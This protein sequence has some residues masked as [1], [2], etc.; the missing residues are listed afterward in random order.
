[1]ADHLHG[2]G[3]RDAGPLKIL[4]RRPSQVVQD[5]PRHAGVEARLDPGPPESFELASALGGVEDPRNDPAG[6][7]LEGL[8]SG[9]VRLE[10]SAEQPGGS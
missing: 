1:V 9:S 5:A 6:H 2:H 8:G 10:R 7:A 3:A 4:H